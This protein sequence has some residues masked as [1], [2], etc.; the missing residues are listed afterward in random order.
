MTTVS[1]GAQC[2]LCQHI[3]PPRIRESLGETLGEMLGPH[4]VILI[5]DAFPEGIPRTIILFTVDHRQPYPGDNG[6]RFEPIV[7]EAE[8]PNARR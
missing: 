2:S 5:C 8:E 1:A 4:E 7:T 6:I 3:R